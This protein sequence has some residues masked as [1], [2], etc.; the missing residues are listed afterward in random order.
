MIC[1]YCGADDDRVIDSRASDGGRSIR[2][3]RQCNAC[4]RRFTTYERVDDT[5][6][7]TVVKRDAAREPFDR[8]K[9]LRSIQTAFGKRPAPD[10]V[11]R[12]LA[13]EVDEELHRLFEREV[14][15]REIGERVAA[16]LRA[17][18][19]IAYVRFASEYYRFENVGE[20]E[21]EIAEL[22]DRPPVSPHQSDLFEEEDG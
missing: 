2:R 5:A 14:D 1:P 21:R 11:K 7:L 4:S 8:Q 18:D 20:I 15:S 10:G 19:P 3:R 13:E 22:K 9:L 6:R 16:R 17:I 12:Q